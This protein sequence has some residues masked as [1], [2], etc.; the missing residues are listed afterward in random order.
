MS[1]PPFDHDHQPKFTEPPHPTWSFRQKV[2]ST[3]EGQ[4]WLEG[5]NQGWKTINTAEY[6][7]M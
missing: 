5:E 3:S 4:A 1:L 6:D 7:R 2:D